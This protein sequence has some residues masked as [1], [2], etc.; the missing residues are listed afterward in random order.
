MA[1][2]INKNSAE[3]QSL[4]NR[5][6][7]SEFMLD[8]ICRYFLEE[9]GR[10][11]HLDEIQNSNSE[12]Y[13]RKFI[14]VTKDDSVEIE[15]V[16]KQTGKEN[17][18]DAVISIN[19]EFRDLETVITPITKKA[20]VTIHHKPTDNNFDVTPVEQDSD[21]HNYFVLEEALYKLA[22]L[23]G[24]KFNTI[25]DAE[26]NSDKWLGLIPDASLV[27]A[28][29]YNGEIY[30]NL[31]RDSLDSPIHE[32]FH[33]F[34]G[35]LRFTNPKL[36]K[37]LIDSIQTLPSYNQLVEK[38]PGRTR[39]DVNE[40]ILVTEVSK[41]LTGYPSA[42]QNMDK[43]TRYEISYNIKRMLDIILMGQDSVKTISEDRLFNLSLKE[44]AQYVNSS[45]MVN[46]FKGTMDV[47]GSELHRVLNNIKSDLY[48]NGTLKEYC[49]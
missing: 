37:S 48:K 43:T 44:I 27:N 35:S 2:C 9:Y 4:K 41:Y 33:M 21:V 10:F 17:L 34:V 15:N 26:L 5:A 36:Y 12:P 7:I 3:Y 23:Y 46:T 24:I 28:F 32:M 30:I 31:D 25:T 11:P 18:Q 8:S 13:L 42:L 40:E 45:V 38:Y 6:G 14:K 22:S 19:D 47:E 49:D 39:N 29:I 1:L 20:L 16:L